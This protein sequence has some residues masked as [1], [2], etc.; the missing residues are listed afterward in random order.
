M[1]RELPDADRQRILDI[2]RTPSRVRS[3]HDLRTRSAGLTKFI[4]LHVVLDPTMPLGRAHVIGD[5]RRGRDPARP[6]RRPRSSCMSIRWD[7]DEP[8]VAPD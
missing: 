2:A 3:V 4:Q 7:D 1:D 8:R 6:S 5:S